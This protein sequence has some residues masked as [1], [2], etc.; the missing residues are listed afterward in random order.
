MI[1][2]VDDTHMLIKEDLVDFVKAQV[3]A[4]NNKNVYTPPT[5]QQQQ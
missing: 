5:E 3:K 2:D 1:L 4:F